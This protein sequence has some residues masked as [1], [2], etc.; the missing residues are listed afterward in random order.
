METVRVEL[1]EVDSEMG[2]PQD[3][4]EMLRSSTAISPYGSPLL[5]PPLLA[6]STNFVA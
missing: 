1:L 3:P 5:P 6:V 2:L 4:A